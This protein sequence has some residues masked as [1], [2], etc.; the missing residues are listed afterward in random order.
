M[1]GRD[2]VA[3]ISGL[4]LVNSEKSRDSNRSCRNRSP[5]D[6]S[7]PRRPR[8]FRQIAR[9]CQRDRRTIRDTSRAICGLAIPSPRHASTAP[10][11]SA[12]AGST[13]ASNAGMIPTRNINRHDV[14]CTPKAPRGRSGLNNRMPITAAQTLPTAESA[15]NSPEVA[16]GRA[17]SGNHLR[18]LRRP[19]ILH[20]RPAP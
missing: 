16:N 2:G 3:R 15:C 7:R 14:R 9:R 12:A 1:P 10:A 8:A 17:R 5:R 11:L 18:Q 20:Q 6:Q 13:S 4:L 19:R